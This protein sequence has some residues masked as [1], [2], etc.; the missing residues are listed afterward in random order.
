M[1][2]DM[3]LSL[4]SFIA[5]MA[6]APAISHLFPKCLPMDYGRLFRARMLSEGLF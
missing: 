4:M 1:M 6:Y 5:K 3:L 2:R